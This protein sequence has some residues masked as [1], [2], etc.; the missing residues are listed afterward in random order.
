MH[1]QD[2]LIDENKVY[3]IND[4]EKI[5][6]VV[7]DF[8]F[9]VQEKYRIAKDRPGSGNTKN[10]GSCVKISELR[11]GTGPFTALGVKVFD[12]YWVNYLTNEMA[13]S[14]KLAKAPYSNLKDYLSYR[15]V[16]NVGYE[17]TDP[18]AKTAGT[19]V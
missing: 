15:N 1:L 6:S 7:R 16:K 10:I 9:I 13:S 19:A 5:L 17:L 11:D 4:L 12:D 3:S 14:A 2:S 8:D 18:K